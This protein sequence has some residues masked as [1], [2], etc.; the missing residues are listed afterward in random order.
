MYKVIW[1]NVDDALIMISTFIGKTV[2][3]I[4]VI[5]WRE[6]GWREYTIP[7]TVTAYKTTIN[8]VIRMGGVIDRWS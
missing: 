7:Y 1:F 4:N 8:M 3:D 6:N 2:K 5:V